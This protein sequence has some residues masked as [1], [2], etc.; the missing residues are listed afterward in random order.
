MVHAEHSFGWASGGLKFE[1]SE[2]T[3][4]TTFGMSQRA[5][6]L[7][8]GVFVVLSTSCPGNL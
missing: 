7:S 4:H 3:A 1:S 8:L 5:F 6:S 2:L